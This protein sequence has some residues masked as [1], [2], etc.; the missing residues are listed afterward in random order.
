MR[1]MNMIL[2]KKKELKPSIKLLMK[3]LKKEKYEET[4]P[5]ESESE[6]ESKP[7]P[8]KEKEKDTS[9]NQ[10][11]LVNLDQPKNANELIEFRNMMVKKAIIANIT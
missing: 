5:S 2:R 4:I 1:L 11:K 9:V 10:R 7:E 3:I 6:S 8:V